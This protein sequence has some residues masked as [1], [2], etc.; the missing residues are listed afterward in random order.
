M[1][2]DQGLPKREK[3]MNELKLIVISKGN[4]CRLGT[5][6]PFLIQYMQFLLQGLDCVRTIE[7]LARVLKKHSGTSANFF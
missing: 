7:E 5:C 3:C 1:N 4:G 2:T 6:L